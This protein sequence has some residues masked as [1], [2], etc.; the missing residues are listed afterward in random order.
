M[1]SDPTCASIPSQATT[2]RLKR[3]PS[4]SR[5]IGQKGSVFQHC[6]PWNSEA[7]AYG[8][9]WIDVPGMQRQRKTVSLGICRTQSIAKQ[10]LCEHIEREGINSKEA[11]ATNTAPA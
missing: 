2:I 10:K 5:R 11:F 3:G 6:K 8:R 7:A 1:S 9:F 4:L